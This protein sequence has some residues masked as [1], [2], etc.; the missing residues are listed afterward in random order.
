MGRCA[1][2]RSP[3]DRQR[4]GSQ[5]Y[6]P[7]AGS[8]PAVSDTGVFVTDQSGTVYA[9]DPTSGGERWRFA[10]NRFAVGGPIVAG[11]SLLQPASD[12]TIFAIDANTG[13][14]VWHASVAD[15]AVIG[16]AATADFV[17]GTYT[18][19]T[20]GFVALATDPAGVSDD[21]MSPTT[22]TPAV[23]CW[24]GSPRRSRSWRSSS[25]RAGRWAAGWARPNSAASMTTLSIRGK[26]SWRR[27]EQ[28]EEAATL[29]HGL[30]VPCAR[31][32]HGPA[33]AGLAGRV[34]LAAIGGRLADAEAALHGR[35]RARDRHGTTVALGCDPGDHVGGV[36]PAHDPRIPGPF[37]AMGVTFAI[38]PVT[39]FTDA[40]VAGKTFRA[41]IGATGV[42]VAGPGLLGIASLLLFHAAVDALVTT[43]SVEKLRTGAV[44]L[45]AVRRAGRVIRTTATVGLI[46]LGLLIAGNVIAAFLGGSA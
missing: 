33:P 5:L 31:Q 32:G 45:W 46:S 18:G 23:C 10:S 14:Q 16:L 40:Q 3:T 35:A 30:D 37:T 12:G 19:A 17:V 15:A 27:R 43:L 2:S 8:P 9:F 25:S 39:T 26:R 24:R 7:T 1:R 42:G 28:Q 29:R 34:A 21:L 36:G 13:H 20:P 6:T 22:P 11:A 44:S 41:A 38:P 4:W